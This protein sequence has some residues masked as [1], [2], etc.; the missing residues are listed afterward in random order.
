MQ[1][2]LCGD[3]CHGG[4]FSWHGDMPHP[5]PACYVVGWLHNVHSLVIS[6]TQHHL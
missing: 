6:C 3:A 5:C 1:T 4:M 2:L